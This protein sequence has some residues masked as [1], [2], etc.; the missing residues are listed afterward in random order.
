MTTAHSHGMRAMQRRALWIALALNLAYLAAEI[1]GGIVFN[2]L[3][4]LADAAHMLSDV[5]GLAIAL[6]AQNLMTRPASARHT[7]G[8]QRSEVLGALANAV[9]LVAVVLW[10]LYE[11]VGRLTDPEPIQG[12]AVIAVASIGLAI[13]VGSARFLQR[14]QGQS[15]NMRGAVVHM[16]SDAFGSVAVIVAGAAALLW[17]ATWVDPAASFVIAGLIL[18]VT[19]RL[20]RDTV[21]VLMEGAPR[22]MDV[23]EVERALEGQNG[24]ASVHHLHLWNLASDVP[25]LSAHVV[26]TEELTLHE[27]QERGDQLR[28]MLHR[29]FGIDHSTLELECHPCVE[30]EGGVSH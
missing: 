3:A 18:V 16:A 12:G 6:Y 29:R 10:I 25:A 11:A 14:A 1:V 17:R 21:H 22:G 28:E 8:F 7:F 23:E 4:L 5:V 24:V 9:T 27:A 19:W 30:V 26:L 13:N 15:L 2:S 20:L